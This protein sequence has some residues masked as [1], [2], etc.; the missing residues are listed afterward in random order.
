MSWAIK[1]LPERPQFPQV[2]DAWFMPGWTEMES[3]SKYYKSHNKQNRPPLVVCLP[4]SQVQYT[5]FCVDIASDDD[6]DKGWTVTGTPPLIT[7][8]PSINAV[9]SYHGYIKNG[10]ISDD[11]EGRKFPHAGKD[12][13][14]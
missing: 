14:C 8:T 3:L 9:G 2:G 12:N 10:I 5:P 11:C 1:L 13:L 6:D 7:V 4:D